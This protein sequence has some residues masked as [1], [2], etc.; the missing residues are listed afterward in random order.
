MLAENQPELMAEA[1]RCL[2]DSDLTPAG[3]EVRPE[4]ANVVTR[5]LFLHAPPSEG[6]VDGYLDWTHLLTIARVDTTRA[7][8]STRRPT[9]ETTPPLHTPTPARLAPD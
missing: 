6:G 4:G 7:D 9:S 5:R 1:R 8:N 3:E 2:L